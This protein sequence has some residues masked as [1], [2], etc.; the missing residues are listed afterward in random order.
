M[1]CQ[2]IRTEA[3]FL[4]YFKR[5]EKTYPNSHVRPIPST[6]GAK[7]DA[8]PIT[9]SQTEYSRP[10]STPAPLLSDNTERLDLTRR[11]SSRQS[12]AV[13]AVDSTTSLTKTKSGRFATELRAHSSLRESRSILANGGTGTDGGALVPT[14]SVKAGK[15]SHDA[16]RRALRTWLRDALSIRS[17]G[18]DN[19]TAAFLLLGS[20][21]PNRH[22]AKDI[23]KRALIDERRK[24]AR[25]AVAQCASDRARIAHEIW[26]SVKDG[27]SFPFALVISLA[28]AR[29]G[30]R[31]CEWRWIQ[32]DF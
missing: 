11:T 17:V 28:D 6:P 15:A 16:Q 12:Q 3:Q 29:H 18:H 8:I 27:P 22:D 26:S 23:V 7:D 32:C 9:P 19:E 4:K 1:H 10:S 5:L 21:V 30:R 14:E 13:S 24:T 31:M 2:V 20:L 25:V